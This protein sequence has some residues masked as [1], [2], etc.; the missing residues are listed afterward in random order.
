M[1]AIQ[2]PPGPSIAEFKETKAEVGMKWHWSGKTFSTCY[3]KKGVVINKQF[4]VH[5]YE[6]K[7]SGKIGNGFA[8]FNP[9]AI[10]ERKFTSIWSLYAYGEKQRWIA[11][12]DYRGRVE[13]R[14]MDLKKRKILFRKTMLGI[15]NSNFGEDLFGIL[16]SRCGN[17][18]LA[19]N[20]CCSSH[21]GDMIIGFVMDKKSFE[22]KPMCRFKIPGGLNYFI[23]LES[24][25][26]RQGKFYFVGFE[27]GFKSK[28]KAMFFYF[29]L[30]EYEIV[31]LDDLDLELEV[32][33]F[34]RVDRFERS[35]YCVGSLGV[36]FEIHV[37]FLE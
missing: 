31:H 10:K 29:D 15:Y 23:C 18:Y 6:V 24:I 8:L 27:G 14:C 4:C 21:K 25:G 11:M 36:M 9:M 3:S 13:L 34:G 19:I 2:D 30:E 33:H 17:Y 7:R 20:S 26:I 28:K 22:L 5:V 1:L 16:I 12:A 32:G 37:E 35:F